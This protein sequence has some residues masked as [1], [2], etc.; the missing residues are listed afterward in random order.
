MTSVA[1]RARRL[2]A[3]SK[4]LGIEPGEFADFLAVALRNRCSCRAP[5]RESVVYR[6]GGSTYVDA[7]SDGHGVGIV[8]HGIRDLCEG[9]RMEHG[10]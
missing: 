2:K 5:I 8:R 9:M 4:S 3:T 7:M 1:I 10:I 6:T